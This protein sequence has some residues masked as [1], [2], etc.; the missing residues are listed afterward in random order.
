MFRVT[1]GLTR[2]SPKN[3]E[4]ETKSKNNVLLGPVSFVSSLSLPK[5]VSKAV[6]LLKI[7][8]HISNQKGGNKERGYK[9]GMAVLDLC[10]VKLHEVHVLALPEASVLACRSFCMCFVFG[11]GRTDGG[12]WRGGESYC[13]QLQDMDALH[14]Y[15]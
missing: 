12:G 14:S 5:L 4:W 11:R 6:G 1:K 3:E 15:F 7:T 8:K 10:Q 2:G 13:F 9:M